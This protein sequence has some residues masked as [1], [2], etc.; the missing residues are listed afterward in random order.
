M[1]DMGTGPLKTLTE[2]IL[3]SAIRA[4]GAVSGIFYNPH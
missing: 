3:V 4:L 1:P 2:N